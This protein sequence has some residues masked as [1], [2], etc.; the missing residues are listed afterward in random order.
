M[1][2]LTLFFALLMILFAALLCGTMQVNESPD[3]HVNSTGLVNQ[4]L[5]YI[6]SNIVYL[7]LVFIAGGLTYIFYKKEL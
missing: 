3:R 7:L 5:S 2:N 1:Y 6:T 4:F